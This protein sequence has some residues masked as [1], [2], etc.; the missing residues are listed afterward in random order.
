MKTGIGIHKSTSTFH[1]PPA[2]EPQ[3]TTNPKG[4]APQVN[5]RRTEPRATPRGTG[6]KAYSSIGTEPPDQP[7]GDRLRENRHRNPQDR[8]NVPSVPLLNLFTS[9]RWHGNAGSASVSHSAINQP[10]RFWCPPGD[11]S[12]P[13]LRLSG[14]SG[15]YSPSSPVRSRPAAASPRSASIGPSGSPHP[16]GPSSDA[17]TH[18]RRIEPPS[19][20]H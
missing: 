6:S 1:H 12:V 7:A 20:N 11:A 16:P 15:T 17:S 3:G 13:C 4:Q 10:Q 19:T 5:A 9:A 8:L 14:C 2:D 18:S